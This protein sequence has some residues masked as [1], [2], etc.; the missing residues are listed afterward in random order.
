MEKYPITENVDEEL[1]KL[2]PSTIC[3]YCCAETFSHESKTF[4]YS[5]EIVLNMNDI[6]EELYDLYTLM[7]K[8][9]IQFRTFIRT[10][11]TNFAFISFGVKYDKELC[12]KKKKGIYAFRVQGKVYYYIND[13]ILLG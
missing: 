7:S 10:Y 11:N 9:F 12:K 8:D 2:K 13:L 3:K 1:D 4:C 6:G 5:G